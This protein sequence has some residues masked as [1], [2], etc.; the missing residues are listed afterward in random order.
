MNNKG[1]AITGI[2]YTVF[3]LFIM[4]LLSMLSGLNQRM[5]ILEKSIEIYND[6]YKALN[7]SENASTCDVSKMNNQ[8]I[9]ACT[10]KYIFGIKND[11]TICITY[12]KKGTRF[13]S[14][15]ISFII[16][17]VKKKKKCQ[18]ALRDSKLFLGEV[19]EFNKGE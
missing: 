11:N 8:Q 6:S 15:K 7:N 1:F 4:V 9:A 2:L 10:G 13:T 5:R 16:K 12:L 14:D 19:Y 17:N 3:I 18:D